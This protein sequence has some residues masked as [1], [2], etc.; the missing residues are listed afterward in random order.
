M[1]TALEP[2]PGSLYE[3]S[4]GP[5]PEGAPALVGDVGYTVGTGTTKVDRPPKP[6]STA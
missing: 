1:S 6:G 2:C 5:R 3:H 4:P